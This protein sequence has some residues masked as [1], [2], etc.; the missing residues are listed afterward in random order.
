MT[1]IPPAGGGGI[2]T[3]TLTLVH[4]LALGRTH[5]SV[6]LI[7]WSVTPPP[8]P[9]PHSPKSVL[10]IGTD[11]LACQQVFSESQEPSLP[12]VLRRQGRLYTCPCALGVWWGRGW[13]VNEPSLEIMQ[14]M[15][16]LPDP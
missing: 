10:H 9:A 3:L 11:K 14:R 15:K 13:L 7:S 6:L 12:W 1:A 4:L 16:Q 2:L 5:A 8:A